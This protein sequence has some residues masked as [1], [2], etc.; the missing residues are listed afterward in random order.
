MYLEGCVL[1][2]QCTVKAVS[3]VEQCTVK[4]LSYVE[5]CTVKAVSCDYDVDLG[6]VL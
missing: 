3:S 4:A 6:C 1:F 2:R 5:Q